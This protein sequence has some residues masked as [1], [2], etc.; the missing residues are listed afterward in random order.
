MM[1]FIIIRML[2]PI[3]HI[4]FWYHK[5]VS[6]AIEFHKLV[7]RGGGRLDFCKSKQKRAQTNF[8]NIFH[9][10]HGWEG[11]GGVDPFDRML[12]TTLK[13]WS[14][15]PFPFLSFVPFP[16]PF[17]GKTR[18]FFIMLVPMSYSSIW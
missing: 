10:P 2:V 6:I 4:S 8:L 18:F 11:G 16:F 3:P 1:I 13:Y 5:M 12:K 7:E 14:R 9:Y 17:N 15:S